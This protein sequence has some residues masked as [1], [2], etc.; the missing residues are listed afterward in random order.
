MADIAPR[1]NKAGGA[2]STTLKTG[3][4]RHVSVSP[5]CHG[6][7]ET[8]EEASTLLRLGAA[9]SGY[10]LT[11]EDG[12][13]MH[14]GS[15]TGWSSDCPEVEALTILKRLGYGRTSAMGDIYGHALAK[16][17]EPA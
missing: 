15:S 17:D 5:S 14:P 11:A 16:S 6:T 10:V 12:G 4:N 13:P 9:P 1:R 8:M 2:I 3:E 7:A